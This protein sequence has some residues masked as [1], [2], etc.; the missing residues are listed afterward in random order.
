MDQ[1]GDGVLTHSDIVPS[2]SYSYADW[3]EAHPDHAHGHGHPESY[4][5]SYGIEGTGSFDP[6]QG[7]PPGP[8]SSPGPD[9]EF[10][11][12]EWPAYVLAECGDNNVLHGQMIIG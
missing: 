1:N 10:E 11:V 4:S 3:L 6:H 12:H 7:H 2:Y 9:P 8:L 5:Y